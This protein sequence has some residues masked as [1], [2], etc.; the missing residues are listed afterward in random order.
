MKWL[1]GWEDISQ[2]TEITGEIVGFWRMVSFT[3]ECYNQVANKYNFKFGAHW[4]VYFWKCLLE[5]KNKFSCLG[6]SHGKVLR[7]RKIGIKCYGKLFTGSYFF[8]VHVS[9]DKHTWLTAVPNGWCM[10][11]RKKEVIPLQ[12]QRGFMIFSTDT[13]NISK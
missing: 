6:K 3:A 8:N 7:R 1:V 13:I 11:C 12:N 5:T 2:V 4:S 9:I 10:S